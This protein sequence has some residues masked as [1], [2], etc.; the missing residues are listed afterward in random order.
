MRQ[1]ISLNCRRRSRAATP[2]SKK[3]KF[4]KHALIITPIGFFPASKTFFRSHGAHINIVPQQRH[5]YILS[6]SLLFFF[7]SPRGFP[8]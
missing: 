1:Q 3:L 2:A 4:N 8:A 5:A 6:L 7:T